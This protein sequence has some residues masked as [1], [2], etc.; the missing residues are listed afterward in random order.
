MTVVMHTG[1]E[2]LPKATIDITNAC[3]C[4]NYNEETDEETPSEFCYG[5]CGEWQQEQF[6]ECTQEFFGTDNWTKRWEF[7]NFPTWRGGRNGGLYARNA[8]EFFEKFFR[9]MSTDYTATVYVWEDR[10]TIR[11]SHHDGSGIM[12]VEQGV[13]ED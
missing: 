7:T 9:G 2:I 8:E 5:D 3:T 6:I 4:T 11:I 1:N 13:M 12:T 10:L